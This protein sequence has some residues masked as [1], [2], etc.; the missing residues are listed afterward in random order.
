[1]VP[2]QGLHV[3]HHAGTVSGWFLYLACYYPNRSEIPVRHLVFLLSSLLLLFSLVHSTPAQEEA[4]AILDKAIKAHGG[5]DKLAKLNITR[6]KAKGTVNIQGQD[7][8]FTS[9]SAVQLPNQE[10]NEL[11]LDLGGQKVTLL[12]VCN[13]DK[14]W[15]SLAG[16]PAQ[17]IMGDQ[18]GEMKNSAYANW[19]ESL[20]PLTKEKEFTLTTLAEM[21]VNNKP[22]VGLKVQAKDRPDIKLYFDKES[23]LLVKS[24]RDGKDETGKMVRM[25]STYSDFKKV[26]GLVQPMKILADR[27]GKRYLEV[28]VTEMKFPDKIDAKLFDKPRPDCDGGEG[29]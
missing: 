26:D 19:V 3:T 18:L 1:M 27:D 23:G 14:G 22:T 20:L 16:R 12:Q 2:S 24:E 17:E 8:G 15:L 4:R 28:E 13:G 11:Q 21:K 10:R 9:D 6:I 29:Q 5:E 25:E 7:V